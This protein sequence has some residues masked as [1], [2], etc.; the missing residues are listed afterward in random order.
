MPTL[1]LSDT[2]AGKDGFETRKRLAHYAYILDDRAESSLSY[3]ITAS[4]AVKGSRS[5]ETLSSAV[6][7]NHSIKLILTS[8]L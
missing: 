3:L 8:E 1:W 5:S 2:L 4:G 7:L 6:R